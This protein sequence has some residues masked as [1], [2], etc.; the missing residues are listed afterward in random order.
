M[1]FT[2]NNEPYTT[3]GTL[4]VNASGDACCERKSIGQHT[5]LGIKVLSY[6]FWLLANSPNSF[7]S[8]VLYNGDDHLAML[9]Q[10]SRILCDYTH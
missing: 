8:C 6:P 1:E 3:L 10:Y 9:H 7:L 2:Y 4:L 5:L